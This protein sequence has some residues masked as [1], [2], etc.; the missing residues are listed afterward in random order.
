MKYILLAFAMLTGISVFS[1]ER[2]NL[3]LIGNRSFT[4][5]TGDNSL[6]IVDQV[7][8]LDSDSSELCFYNH[9]LKFQIRNNLLNVKW[10]D[11]D[12]GTYECNV[13]SKV[14]GQF[15]IIRFIVNEQPVYY[16]LYR[17]YDFLDKVWN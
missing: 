15:Y 9:Y 8:Y 6:N 13:D 16:Y 5:F 7:Y 17:R 10:L 4:G 1:Q 2:Y 3:F 12:E 14:D 11:E